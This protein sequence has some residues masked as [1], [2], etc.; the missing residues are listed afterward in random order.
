MFNF[1]FHVHP[2]QAW[3]YI[4]LLGSIIAYRIEKKDRLREVDE[5]KAE[6]DDIRRRLERDYGASWRSY[7]NESRLELKGEKYNWTHV[8]WCLKAALFSWLY[9]IMRTT[10]VVAEHLS[11]NSPPSWL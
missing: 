10:V 2:I 6:N 5:A 9:V 8:A 11:K 3:V 4:Y 1:I 7:V